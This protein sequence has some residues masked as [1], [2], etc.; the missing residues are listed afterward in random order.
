MSLSYKRQGHR[1]DLANRLG[2]YIVSAVVAT[3][4]DT[5]VYTTWRLTSEYPEQISRYIDF[6]RGLKFVSEQDFP[7]VNA[8]AL[9]WTNIYRDFFLIPEALYK[10]LTQDKLINC[11]YTTMLT[12][13]REICNQVSYLGPLPNGFQ[14]RPYVIH[15]SHQDS[16]HLAR[17]SDLSQRC[18]THNW[19]YLGPAIDSQNRSKLPVSLD[20]QPDWSTD[21]QIKGLEE[22]FYLSHCRI[23]IQS[24]PGK[25]PLSGWSS[26]SYL[27]HQF[28]MAKYPDS[29]PILLSC[30]TPSEASRFRYCF[31]YCQQQL[32]NVYLYS[33]SRQ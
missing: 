20:S 9:T 3:L 18:P 29:A 31:N 24:F 22:F 1:G 16:A 23:I 13:Y 30:H 28:G 21:P 27:A 7:S 17:I 32:P 33:E 14:N 2:E 6:P 4:N 12:C 19:L 10:S 26:L 25:G 5:V 15:T 8:K 11:D